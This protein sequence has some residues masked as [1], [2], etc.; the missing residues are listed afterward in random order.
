MLYV[1]WML[2]L[3]IKTPL[4]ILGKGRIEGGISSR[5]KGFWDRKER[6]WNMKQVRSM[7][8]EKREPPT[9]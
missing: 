3:S 2:H 9:W 5:Q 4:T 6:A 1:T 7:G 8:A